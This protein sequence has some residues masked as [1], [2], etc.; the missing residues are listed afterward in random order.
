M[1]TPLFFSDG[2]KRYTRSSDDL[3]EAGR[4]VLGV[5]AEPAFDPTGQ[6][7]L[8]GLKTAELEA[9]AK[10]EGVDVSGASNNGERVDLIEAARAD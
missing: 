4:K 9:V 7:A 8:S 6:P 1:P 5:E 2:A 3:P 10:A